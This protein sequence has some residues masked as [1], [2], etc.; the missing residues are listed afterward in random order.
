MEFNMRNII[1][2]VL[3]IIIAILAFNS[4]AGLWNIQKQIVEGFNP[5][6]DYNRA[7]PGIFAFNSDYGPFNK[8]FYMYPD[9]IYQPNQ[10]FKQKAVY[11]GGYRYNP[12]YSDYWYIPKYEYMK[13]WMGSPNPGLNSLKDVT[14]YT[15]GEYLQNVQN[16]SVVR[17]VEK[18]P[19]NAQPFPLLQPTADVQQ[20]WQNPLIASTNSNCVI[21][22]SISRDCI[23]KRLEQNGNLDLAI[24]S[25]FV[26]P[27]VSAKC[28]C[29]LNS[30]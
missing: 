10:P 21:P 6:L 26:P 18:Y 29:A 1:V 7:Y 8:S 11:L 13:R 23:N 30:K 24:G 20:Y 27:S 3:G 15:P 22:P 9:G 12:G 25:C 5:Y 4:L 2:I 19:A 28:A 16:I 17:P 14:A